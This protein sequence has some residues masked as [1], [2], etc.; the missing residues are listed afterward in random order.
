MPDDSP[1]PADPNDLRDSAA[2]RIAREA[3]EQAQT[4]SIKA[5]Q[6][7]SIATR[8]EASVAGLS[9]AV[10]RT[11]SKVDDLSTRADERHAE[12]IAAIDGAKRADAE[13]ARMDSIHEEEI[14][15][16]K[17][18]VSKLTNGD[19]A[20]ISGAVV[21]LIM[22][23]VAILTA[24]APILPSVLQARYA[25]P[26]LVTVPLTAAPVPLTS[27]SQAPSVRP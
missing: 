8:S 1:E 6:A 11:E 16:V 3:K 2:L 18:S 24:L 17:D 9:Y 19:V 5:D 20:K 23:I 27:G 7:I 21:A 25:P 26:V 14:K 12:T 10:K 13:R 4:A 22:A 15:A